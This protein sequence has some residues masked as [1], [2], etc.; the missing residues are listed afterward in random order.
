MFFVF[1]FSDTVQ[2]RQGYNEIGTLKPSLNLDRSVSWNNLLKSNLVV[3][4]RD[5]KKFLPFDPV[6]LLC[7]NLHSRNRWENK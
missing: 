3:S 1:V 6:T 5:H 4:I 2:D 7:S